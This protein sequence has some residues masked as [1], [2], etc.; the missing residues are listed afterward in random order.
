MSYT[1]P[2]MRAQAH[3]GI[4]HIIVCWMLGVAVRESRRTR[5]SEGQR[6]EAVHISFPPG[7]RI[8]SAM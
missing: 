3:L 6:R 5:G 8:T 7:L 4:G 2:L 1:S